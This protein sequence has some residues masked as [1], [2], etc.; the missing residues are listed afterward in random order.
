MFL[1]L[2]VLFNT[3]QNLLLNVEIIYDVILVCNSMVQL[4]LW[5]PLHMELLY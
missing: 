3:I 1:K 4:R 2:K 5:I